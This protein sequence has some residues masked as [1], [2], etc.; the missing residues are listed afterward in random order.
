MISTLCV[1][2]IIAE[3]KHIFICYITVYKSTHVYI[4]NHII[5]NDNV[6]TKDGTGN[7][8]D[9]KGNDQI[10]EKRRTQIRVNV[11]ET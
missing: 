9:H 3:S 1:F 11:T 2:L 8:K 10:T 5:L 4:S 7:Q 6:V